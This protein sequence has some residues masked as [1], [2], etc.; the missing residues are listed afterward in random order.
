MFQCLFGAAYSTLFQYLFEAAYFTLFQC[1]LDTAHI[2]HCSVC[3]NVSSKQ[4]ICIGVNPLLCEAVKSLGR[5]SVQ[6]DLKQTKRDVL[7]GQSSAA[8]LAC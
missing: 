3:S 6:Q 1:L 4:R 5:A 2:V 7:E 8:K